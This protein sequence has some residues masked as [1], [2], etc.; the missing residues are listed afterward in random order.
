MAA[1]REALKGR[2]GRTGHHATCGALPLLDP[3]S[4]TCV[5][6]VALADLIQTR[7]HGPS[8]RPKT[9]RTALDEV[10]ELVKAQQVLI[11]SSMEEVKF[12]SRSLPMF[13]KHGALR[14]VVIKGSSN[15]R[16]SEATNRRIRKAL[17]AY[18]FKARDRM[19]DLPPVA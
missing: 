13:T 10:I 18:G 7:A 9:S 16:L 2:W 8:P 3:T 15:T 4:A 14:R 6:V 17:L 12:F 5:G 1:V 19:F 11:I